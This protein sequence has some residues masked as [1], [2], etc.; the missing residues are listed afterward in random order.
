MQAMSHVHALLR[1]RAQ[2][3]YSQG[4]SSATSVIAH[5]TEEEWASDKECHKHML[6]AQQNN[7]QL[8]LRIHIRVLRHQI[9]SVLNKKNTIGYEWLK[10]V[11]QKQHISVKHDFVVRNHAITVTLHSGTTQWKI[12]GCAS[13]FS[14]A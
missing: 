9:C 10:D 8:D 2:S 5:Q 11:N 12:I 3:S 1:E 6:R 7:M 13:M 14:S 4:K